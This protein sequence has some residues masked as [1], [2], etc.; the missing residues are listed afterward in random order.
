MEGKSSPTGCSDVFGCQ[1]WRWRAQA[2]AGLWEFA[3]KSL[4]AQPWFPTALSLALQRLCHSDQ[5]A[6]LP[7]LRRCGSRRGPG[8]VEKKGCLSHRAKGRH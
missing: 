4:T 7:V 8:T 5:T 2:T 3:L 6:G 1:S